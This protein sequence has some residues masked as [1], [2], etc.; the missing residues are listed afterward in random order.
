M[1]IPQCRSD[2][3]CEDTVCWLSVLEKDHCSPQYKRAD[4]NAN[5]LISLT[6]TSSGKNARRVNGSP[7][8][9]ISCTIVSYAFHTFVVPVFAFYHSFECL[10]TQKTLTNTKLCSSTNLN[11]IFCVLY[12]KRRCRY[13]CYNRTNYRRNESFKH[14]KC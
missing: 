3:A 4:V 13:G 6:A 5:S 12:P 9:F 10:S 7:T 8:A 1:C 2:T 11:T 14:K